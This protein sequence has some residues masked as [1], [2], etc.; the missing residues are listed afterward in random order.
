[1]LRREYQMI[2]NW[3]SRLLFTSEDQ[4]CTNFHVQ[5]QSTDMTSQYPVSH[6]CVTSQANLRYS[7]VMS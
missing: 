3:Y 1:M 5:E 7:V 4:L 6:A 2:G